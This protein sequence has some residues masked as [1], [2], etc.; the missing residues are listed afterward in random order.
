MLRMK[1]LAPL[2]AYAAH[3]DVRI[4]Y[5]GKSPITARTLEAPNP[6]TVKIYSNGGASAAAEAGAAGPDKGAAARVG[7]GLG[8][9]HPLGSGLL[10]FT[11]L[12]LT[13][14]GGFWLYVRPSGSPHSSDNCT[15]STNNS[16]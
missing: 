9:I 8:L 5:T 4:H 7:E 3:V 2:L 12:C 11:V 15:C 14:F 16:L 6:T 13:I 1:V 10:Q